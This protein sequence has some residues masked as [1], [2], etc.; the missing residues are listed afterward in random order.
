MQ[1]PVIESDWE[2]NETRQGDYRRPSFLAQEVRAYGLDAPRSRT[3]HRETWV[4]LR[5][6]NLGQI[7]YFLSHYCSLF[8]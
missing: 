3:G 2:A 6:T 7:H 1:M 4:P 5:A 8:P